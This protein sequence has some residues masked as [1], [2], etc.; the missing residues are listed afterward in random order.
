MQ[1]S[2]SD[3][4][5][6]INGNDIINQMIKSAT[7]V[8]CKIIHKSTLTVEPFELCKSTYLGELH[9]LHKT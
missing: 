3:S 9:H 7:A 8:S 1:S 4:H 6:D 2:S 5:V